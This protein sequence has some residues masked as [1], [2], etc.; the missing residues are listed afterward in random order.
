MLK[1]AINVDDPADLL[2]GYGAG[3]LIRVERA[4]TSAFLDATEIMTIPIVTGTSRYERWDT[5]GTSDHWYRVRYSTASPAVATD[6]SDYSDGFQVTASDVQAWATPA[7]MKLRM[8]IDDS[9]DDDLMWQYAMEANSWLQGR[10]GRPVGPVASTTYFFDGSDVIADGKCLPVPFGIR[11]VSALAVRATTGDA[12]TSIPSSD[13]FLRPK[14]QARDTGWPATQVW[15]TDNPSSGNGW[16]TRFPCHGFDAIQMTASAGWDE[17]PA[18]L[19]ELAHRLAVSSFRAR[20]YGTGA[21]YVVGED[22]ERV[23][24]R[25]MSARDWGTVR[26]YRELRV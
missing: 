23:F 6:H 21:E 9:N 22:G 17:Q 20:A 11:S 26:F 25:E 7:G 4:S 5:T 14:P 1:L 19:V 12:Y 18:D 2:S 15:L 16:G 10:I 8:G 24:E 3:A 13:Y